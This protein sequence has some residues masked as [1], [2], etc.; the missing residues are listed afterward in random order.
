MP[1]P[2]HRLINRVL[3]I[4]EEVMAPVKTWLPVGEEDAA[5]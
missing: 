5:L 3:G 1:E 2:Q 4:P